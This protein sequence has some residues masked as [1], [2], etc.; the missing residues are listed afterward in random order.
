[1]CPTPPEIPL[2]GVQDF[3]PNVFEL[4]PDQACAVVGETMAPKCHSFLSIYI[5]SASFGRKGE[6]NKQMCDGEKD[7]DRA[8]PGKD[9]LESIQVLQQLRILCQ[10]K[11]SCSI[12]VE[13]SMADFT[14][15]M[16][17]D[18]KRELRLSHICGMLASCNPILDTRVSVLLLLLCLSRSNYTPFNLKLGG[19]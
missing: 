14:G 6:N 8:E 7:D 19:L 18:L 15:C 3:V 11:P 4:V 13:Q 16:N 1:M 5:Q 17:A 2:E 9:C 10:G 12:P